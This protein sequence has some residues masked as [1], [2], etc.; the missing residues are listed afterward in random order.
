MAGFF[1]AV[2]P[3]VATAAETIVAH[4]TT[5]AMTIL[6]VGVVMG[7]ALA[8]II[9][10]IRRIRDHGRALK[11]GGRF[12][13]VA[14]FVGDWVWEM[15]TELRFT[16]LSARFF[17]LFPFAPE[18]ILGKTRT[19]YVG[20][21]DAT[22]DSVWQNHFRTIGAQQPFRDF[23]YALT[24]ETGRRRY[25]RISGRP[26]YDSKGTYKGYQGTGADLTAEVEATAQAARAEAALTD[27]LE[28]IFRRVCLI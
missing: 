5:S 25:V 3:R 9:L 16:Y 22:D 26:V 24:D 7:V 14:D 1:L 13:D 15:D 27:A 19:E 4:E 28:S 12:R 10:S 18:T 6:G 23:K 21:A 11:E 2:F 17:E 8:L 20:A